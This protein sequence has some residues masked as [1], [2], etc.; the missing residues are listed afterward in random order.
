M[1]G[2]SVL[3]SQHPVRRQAT[4]QRAMTNEGVRLKEE[5]KQNYDGISK[6]PKLR[7][8]LAPPNQKESLLNLWSAG[9]NIFSVVIQT[10][11]LPPVCLMPYVLLL[12]GAAKSTESRS[13][14]NPILLNH[15]CSSARPTI[16]LAVVE[17]RRGRGSRDLV[18]R[19]PMIHLWNGVTGTRDTPHVPPCTSYTPARCCRYLAHEKQL[20]SP[21]LR[22]L[23]HKV[24]AA[25]FYQVL[26]NTTLH[27]HHLLSI[28][29]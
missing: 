23:C 6:N 1:P 17:R 16:E 4:Q 8:I 3:E 22:P 18:T 7:L 27:R 14:G 20:E 26:H 15:G 28:P 12:R 24:L 29:T 13:F 19:G 5:A 2:I 21:G 25:D 11:D 9:P 10:G